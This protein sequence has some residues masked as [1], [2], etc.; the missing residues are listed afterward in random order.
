MADPRTS[1]ASLQQ[2][3][4]STPKSNNTRDDDRQC[5]SVSTTVASARNEIFRLGAY[6]GSMCT[7]FLS[8]PNDRSNSSNASS[9]DASNS[10]WA[11]SS[12]SSSSSSQL[13]D[14]VATQ[15]GMIFI[16]LFTICNVCDIDLCTSVL[17]KVELNG[18][19]YPVELCKGK[20]GKYTNYSSQTGIT[21]SEGQSTIDSPIKDNSDVDVSRNDE[22][23]GE[24]DTTTVEGITFLIRHFANERLWNRFHT[25]RNIVLALLGEVGELAELFQW[26]GDVDKTDESNDNTAESVGGNPFAK[27]SGLM[28]IGWTEEEVDKVGQEVADVTIYLI[29]LADICHVSLAKNAVRLLEERGANTDVL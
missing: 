11:A 13:R 15:L 18:R 21:K 29:R 7:S 1:F 20:S 28:T 16:Q 17:K 27:Q 4:A 19:K 25:P 3:I 14:E 24:E 2:Q 6:A 5:S 26:S 10:F 12:S 22:D 23:G 9:N 8:V